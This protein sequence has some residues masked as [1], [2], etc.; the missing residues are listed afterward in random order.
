MTDRD[1]ATPAEDDEAGSLED[2]V[3]QNVDAGGEQS[4]SDGGNTGGQEES[5]EG[6]SDLHAEE[7][8][9]HAQAVE[10]KG[11]K[12]SIGLK[13]LAAF[14]LVAAMTVVV[15]V[16][17]WLNIGIIGSKLSTVTTHDLPRVE[18]SLN[19]SKAAERLSAAA[20]QLAFSQSEEERAKAYAHAGEIINDMFLLTG[21]GT[22]GDA[23]ETSKELQDLTRQMQAALDAINKSVTDRLALGQTM[24]DMIK[25]VAGLE[26]Q[27][28][29]A[30]NPIITFS[31]L[32]IVGIREE[33]LKMAQ[34]AKTPED[35]EK[36]VE[37]GGSM[38][39]QRL[40]P[41]RAAF[42]MQ[43]ATSNTFSVLSQVANAPDAKTLDSLEQRYLDTIT[44]VA[45]KA[46]GI[47]DS[48]AKEKLDQFVTDL[49]NFG[50]MKPSIFDIRRQQLDLLEKSNELLAKKDQI[51]KAINADAQK[52]VASVKQSAD[53]NSAA[54]QTAVQ[55]TRLMAI[56]FGAGSLIIAAAIALFYVRNR[57]IKRLTDLA[58]IMRRLAE[59]D[60]S[61]R[62]PRGGNDEL[63]AMALTLV[64]FR[65]NTR[66]AREAE[67]L[68]EEERVR[69]AQAR[70]S[71]MNGLADSFEASV[72]RIVENVSNSAGHVKTS[73]E[74]LVGVAKE[75]QSQSEHSREMSDRT[76]GNMQSVSAATEEMTNSIEEIAQQVNKSVE[77]AR[78][79]VTEITET[80]KEIVGLA[81][82]AREIGS[83]VELISEIA[84][85]TNMLAL[86]ATIEAAR[87][88]EAGKGFAVV[89]NEV[90]S[91]ANQT[92]QATEQISRQIGTIQSSTDRAVTAMSGINRI[93]TEIDEIAGSIASA[94]EEQGAV[95]Q[96]IARSIADT[97]TATSDVAESIE[98]VS[99]AAGTTGEEANGLLERAAEMERLSAAL[100]E[101]VTRFLNTVRNG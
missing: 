30:I 52:L 51:A 56:L 100:G 63:T 4:A 21:G 23:D 8:H 5:S 78:R 83:V 38:T 10:T 6:T 11:R 7:S 31:N 17:A 99:T 27:A 36:I 92:V 60:L 16:L 28:T 50:K 86:N 72:S 89:A 80:D 65:E 75:A 76:Q 73:A 3:Q 87:A 97:T 15:S 24:N 35:F 101:E 42:E 70:K 49:V 62:I 69:S 12:I 98:A 47:P 91:L 61:V 74:S 13:L 96:D 34:N 41:F 84:D 33:L 44:Q 79:A 19:L 66:R 94:V 18:D 14:G 29:Q 26:K 95:T 81:D 90:K 54:A 67:Q 22:D 43:S 88:G 58:D 57:L 85:Q 25:T 9:H 55:S 64:T 71:E 46:Y 45:T 37:E 48:P 59:G 1:V 77:I 53:A 32:S 40:R 68:Q 93:I 2:A 20:P 82:A 39:T